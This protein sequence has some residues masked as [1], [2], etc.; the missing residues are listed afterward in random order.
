MR[1]QGWGILYFCQ[2]HEN[3]RVQGSAGVPQGWESVL[4]SDSTPCQSPRMMKREMAISFL[5][6]PG[7]LQPF[8]E[9]SGTAGGWSVLW[10]RLIHVCMSYEDTCEGL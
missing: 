6:W 2:W 7:T 9:L 3:V 10:P 8:P 1:P 5:T 4:L